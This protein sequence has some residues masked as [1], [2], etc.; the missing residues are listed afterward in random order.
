MIFP[1]VYIMKQVGLAVDDVQELRKQGDKK[2]MRIMVMI[3][4]CLG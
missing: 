1:L 2:R 4:L 3:I